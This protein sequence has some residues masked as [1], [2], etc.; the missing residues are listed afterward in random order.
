MRYYVKTP[1]NYCELLAESLL[2]MLNTILSGRLYGLLCSV[3]DRIS[4]IV[5]IRR[6][7]LFYN[8]STWPIVPSVYFGIDKATA[9]EQQIE[10]S[11]QSHVVG[12]GV[13]VFL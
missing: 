13:R 8:W 5:I 4:E 7:N 6:N 12:S 11:L 2:Y 1:R 3:I 9:E 10:V